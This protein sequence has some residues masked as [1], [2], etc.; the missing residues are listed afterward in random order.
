MRIFDLEFL[1][2]IPKSSN[3]LAKVSYKFCSPLLLCNLLLNY[4]MPYND[5]TYYKCE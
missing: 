2:K 1:H 3:N 4:I 5:C